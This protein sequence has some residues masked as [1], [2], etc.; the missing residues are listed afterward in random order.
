MLFWDLSLFGVTAF[1]VRLGL[2][3]TLLV[4]QV[5]SA[6]AACSSTLVSTDSLVECETQRFSFRSLGHTIWRDVDGG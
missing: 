4:A 3:A 2:M 1:M 5:V 6:L